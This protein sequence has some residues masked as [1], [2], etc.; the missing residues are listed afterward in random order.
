MLL[1]ELSRS[2]STAAFI[3]STLL[4]ASLSLSFPPPPPFHPNSPIITTG[5]DFAAWKN[6]FSNCPRELEPT[7]IDLQDA[8]PADFPTGTYYRNGHARFY[9][10]DSTPCLHP[11][12]ADGMI[13]AITFDSSNP[14]QVL[15]RNKFVQTEAY[16]KDKES[17]GMS[18]RGLFGTL[19]SGGRI[20][21]LFQ[22]SY[23]HV[24]N[25]N[26]LHCGDTLY[27]LWEG[28][29]PYALDPLTLC[30][31]NG[32]GKAGLT[33]LGG[34]LTANFSAHPRY[35]PVRNTYT[36]FG[37]VFNP[38]KSEFRVSLYEVDATTFRSKRKNG[39]IPNFVLDAPA[40]L[41]DFMLTT[42]YCILLINETRINVISAFKAMLGFGGFAGCIE[43]D[44][45]AKHSHFVLIPRSL[46][47]EDQEA[48]M[49]LIYF[50][51]NE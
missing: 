10:D 26:V 31:K 30:N 6:A 45:D 25:T 22:M 41:H 37:A 47:D 34:L 50:K 4:Y 49:T 38:I 5:I 15:F 36:N 35:D 2:L 13:V 19:K 40:L 43:A 20:S 21:N 33:D 24:A 14:R 28:G 17:G 51:T 16:I 42:N 9:A 44:K 27:A 23:K 18:Q 12:D 32:I 8:L 3:I 11:F 48:V 29:K 1:I 7:I 39:A 46:F